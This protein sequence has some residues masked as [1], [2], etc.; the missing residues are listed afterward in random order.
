MIS[1]VI[2]GS[3]V[4][5]SLLLTAW[6]L[7]RFA[8]L[9]GSERGKFRFGMAAALLML[10]FGVV[11]IPMANLATPI[12]PSNPLSATA[13]LLG[14]QA[15]VI[16][17]IVRWTFAL[18]R[19][20]GWMPFGALVAVKLLELVFALF[21][22]KLFISEAFVIPT[23][24]MSPTL[25]PGDRFVVNKLVRPRRLD[26]V[27]YWADAPPQPSIFCQRLI[28]LP[29]ERLRF[30]GGG[31]FIN[32]QPIDL[33]AV[34]AGRCRAAPGGVS[35]ARYREGETIVLADDEIF[36]IGD[37]LD[38]SYDSRLIGPAQTGPQRRRA[39]CVESAP[40]RAHPRQILP[41]FADLS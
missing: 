10:L 9:A 11:F 14:V 36:L 40:H 17:Q 18:S 37:N 1:L 3:I 19:R 35:R 29:G 41:T 23:A 30:E 21:V 38:A 7:A 28:G 24:G 16:F 15:L 34:I 4:I 13:I 26:I 12:L 6:V 2:L 8:R 5:G 39:C 20:R 25:E 27:A 32:D 22:L 33:P 31:L